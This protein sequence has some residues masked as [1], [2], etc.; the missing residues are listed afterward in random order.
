ML[1]IKNLQ[2]KLDAYVNAASSGNASLAE[3]KLIN[4]EERVETLLE[5]GRVSENDAQRLLDLASFDSNTADFDILRQAVID[6]GNVD[7]LNRFNGNFT[8]FAPTDRAFLRL[9][10]NLGGD[11][12]TEA[13]AYEEIVDALGGFDGGAEEALNSV[14]Q[15]H[16]V[17]GQRAKQW[18]TKTDYQTGDIVELNDKYF[19]ATEDH[20]SGREFKGRFWDRV[21]RINK[22]STTSKSLAL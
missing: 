6:T 1:S 14:I 17:R 13:E 21:K 18:L 8:V 3:K 9:A 15:Y 19:V 4:Y 11:A 10:E 7:L 16:I 22:A 20:F 2:V 5:K 12:E